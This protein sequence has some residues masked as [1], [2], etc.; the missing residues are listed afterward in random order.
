LISDFGYEHDVFSI[1]KVHNKDY[2]NAMFSGLPPAVQQSIIGYEVPVHV[3]SADTEDRDILQIFARLNSTG[4][5]LNDQELRNAEFFGAFKSQ[6]YTMA[7]ENLNRWQDWK[8]FSL[9]DISRMLEVEEV[10]DL[11]ISMHEGVHA[12]NKTTLDSYYQKYDEHYPE[13]AVVEKRF[14][15]V[16]SAI[17]GHVGLDLKNLQ[18]SKRALFNDLFVSVYHLMYGIGSPLKL[19]QKAEKLPARF[20]AVL[21]DLSEKIGQDEAGEAVA[22]SLRGATSHFGS[23]LVRTN[24]ILD[25]FGHVLT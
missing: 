18:F 20:A 11:I 16:M 5:K 13:G 1:S 24:Y 17:E 9:S 22:R 6:V 19:S 14:D 21:H 7:Y 2:A 12:K 10:S 8:V 25:A 3:F 4:V 23:R 15:S